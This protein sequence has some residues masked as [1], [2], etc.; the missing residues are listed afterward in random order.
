MY[1]VVHYMHI[2]SFNSLYNFNSSYIQFFQLLLHHQQVGTHKLQ[3]LNFE[4]PLAQ[5]ME[6]LSCKIEILVI[7]F[8][9][10]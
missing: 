3:L 2:I 6:S 1:Y 4:Y 9:N 7:Q 8:N 5:K 10:P